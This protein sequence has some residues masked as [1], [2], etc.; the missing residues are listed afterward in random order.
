MIGEKKNIRKFKQ[1]K[2]YGNLELTDTNKSKNLYKGNRNFSPCDV[3]DA[4]GTLIG[5]KHVIAWKI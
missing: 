5:E 3:C 4:K 1:I 2:F